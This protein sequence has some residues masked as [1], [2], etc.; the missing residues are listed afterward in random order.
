[1]NLGVKLG[2]R[3]EEVA[4]FVGFGYSIKETANLL[5]MP[6]N[7]V[8]STLKVVYAKIGIQKATELSKFV[9]CRRFDIP[10]SLCEPVRQVIALFLLII[11]IGSVYVNEEIYARRARRLSRTERYEDCNQMD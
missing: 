8:K 7:T 1:M 9:F 11:Y 2:K 4:E 10:L 6:I 5:N 3:Q